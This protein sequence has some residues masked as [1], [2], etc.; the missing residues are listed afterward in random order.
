[1]IQNKKNIILQLNQVESVIKGKNYAEKGIILESCKETNK[2]PFVFTLLTDL[3]FD[4][5]WFE[6]LLDNNVFDFSTIPEP[7]EVIDADGK[8]DF[9]LSHW[10]AS[11]ILKSAYQFIGKTDEPQLEL[12]LLEYLNKYIDSVAMGENKENPRNNLPDVFF[13]DYI[14]SLKLNMISDKHFNFLVNFGLSTSF[15]TVAD[16][17]VTT[18]FEKLYEEKDKRLTKKI[19]E[20]LFTP[21]QFKDKIIFRLDSRVKNYYVRQFVNSST[22]KLYKILGNDLVDWLMERII[23]LSNQYPFEF[24]KSTIVSISKDEQNWSDEGMNK[25]IVDLLKNCLELDEMPQEFKKDITINFV[26][27]TNDIIRRIGLHILDLN[28]TEY[29]PIFW[30]LENPLNDYEAKLEV[31]KLIRNHCKEM[32]SGEIDIVIEWIDSIHVEKYEEDDPTIFE[33][34][35]A[36]RKKEWYK[37][38]EN[39]ANKSKVTIEQNVKKLMRISDAEPSH[40]GYDSWSESKFG[41]DYSKNRITDDKI[42]NVANRINDENKWGGYNISGIQDDL[43][44]LVQTKPFDI[45]KVID[46]FSDVDFN[47]LYYFFDGF[48]QISKSKIEVDWNIV[49]VFIEDLL[50]KRTEIWDFKNDKKYD[51]SGAL[52]SISWFLKEAASGDDVI[53]KQRSQLIKAALILNKI[54]NNYQRPF[55]YKNADMTLDV[56]NSTRGKVYDAL[57]TISLT[58]ARHFDGGSQKWEKLIEDQFTLRLNDGSQLDEFYWTIGYYTPQIGY[59]NHSWIKTNK[60][61]IYINNDRIE[62]FSFRGYLHLSGRLYRDLY[63]ILYTKY[64]EAISEFNSYPSECRRLAEHIMIAYIENLQG[65]DKL[66]EKLFYNKNVEQIK[67]VIDF[68]R[69]GYRNIKPEQLI[70]IW[71]QIIA[72]CIEIG[73]TAKTLIFYTSSFIKYFQELNEETIA[74]F[75]KSITHYTPDPFNSELLSNII[76]LI[77]RNPAVGGDLF[78]SIVTSSIDSDMFY[79]KD[80]LL[81][82]I[83]SLYQAG[84]KEVAN[85]ICIRIVEMGQ[86]YPREIYNQF[87]GIVIN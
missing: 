25:A 70:Y 75:K 67:S 72:S 33:Q 49:L 58:L 32:T 22:G 37:A 23:K 55:N 41:G 56:I 19:L 40:P 64:E 8:K 48:R 39:V 74:L 21:V 7:H 6:I 61:K 3:S 12:Q 20:I 82:G 36:Y 80:L 87:N 24:S 45:I 9:W 47:F 1:M 57:I 68:L 53:L 26:N 28:Y 77:E 79:N 11:W 5:R 27:E 59:L 63:D 14:F 38:L 81:K 18:F 2:R 50:S 30:K 76:Q 15:S 10:D 66:I 71:S 85:I 42:E 86:Y 46:T 29:A 54:D 62:N 35:I 65:S 4:K 44:Y 83:R 43:R 16:N 17:L 52:D 34:R 78:L 69:A 31:F 51:K 73:D 60:D 84:Q 13:S